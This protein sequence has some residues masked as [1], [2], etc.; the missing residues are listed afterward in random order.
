MEGPLGFSPSKL[1]WLKQGLAAAGMLRRN[2][3][4]GMAAGRSVASDLGTVGGVAST[5]AGRAGAILGRGAKQAGGI[6][7]RDLAAG[8]N[9]MMGG[10]RS[11]MASANEMTSGMRSRAAEMGTQAMGKWKALPFATKKKVMLGTLAGS[12]AANIGLGVSNVISRR[13][14][15]R[16]NPY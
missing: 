2:A 11:G 5:S 7:G 1:R 10:L 8:G 12:T 15:N 13:R 9:R 4:S 14:A 3:R 6:L 16:Q